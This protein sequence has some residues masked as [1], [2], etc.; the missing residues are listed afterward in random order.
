MSQKKAREKTR[1][2]Y[3]KSFVLD[4][5]GDRSFS[6]ITMDVSISGAKLEMLNLS[7]EIQSGDKGRLR[8][9]NNGSIFEVACEVVRLEGGVVGLHLF[10]KTTASPENED[11]FSLQLSGGHLHIGDS[12]TAP[13][14]TGDGNPFGLS[15]EAGR[16]LD[17]LQ[18]KHGGDAIDIINR[19]LMQLDAADG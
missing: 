12:D 10:E 7:E 13:G 9:A 15:T 8:L 11:S 18:K 6:G 19:A 17:R 14:Q 1:V 2:P 16:A 5:G 4:L 3:K